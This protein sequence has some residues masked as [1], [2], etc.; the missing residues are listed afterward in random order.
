LKYLLLILA[1]GSRKYCPDW[2]FETVLMCKVLRKFEISWNISELPGK[3]VIIISQNI[4]R[5]I[6]IPVSKNWTRLPPAENNNNKKKT[7]TKDNDVVRRNNKL[8]AYRKECRSNISLITLISFQ[9]LV[10]EVSLTDKYMF[11]F[12]YS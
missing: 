7:K 2:H 1:L 3:R 4:C 8:C 5:T 12:F 6:K 11:C 10:C 9:I